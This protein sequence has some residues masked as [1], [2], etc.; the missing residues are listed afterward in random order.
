MPSTILLKKP[1]T[2]VI[3]INAAAQDTWMFQ[4]DKYFTITVLK[5]PNTYFSFSSLLLTDHT[6]ILLQSKRY[7]WDFFF[8]KDLKADIQT[9]LCPDNF[10]RIAIFDLPNCM[11]YN[12][13]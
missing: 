8:K 5:E 7:D 13:N 6:A 9:Y 1:K 12:P 11:Q 2:F 4:V 3:K 10:K